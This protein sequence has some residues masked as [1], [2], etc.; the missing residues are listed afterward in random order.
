MPATNE[1]K[2]RRDNGDG[3]APKQQ[4]DGQWFR[5]ITVEVKSNC[6]GNAVKQITFSF[7]VNPA[8]TAKRYLPL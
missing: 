5:Q 8:G 1:T 2:T 6:K 3:T 4:G 7:Q